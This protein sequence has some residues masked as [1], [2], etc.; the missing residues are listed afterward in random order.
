MRTVLITN[1]NLSSMIALGDWLAR[2]PARIEKIFV[3]Y[4]LPSSKGNWSGLYQMLKRSGVAYTFLKIWINRWAPQRVGQGS[5]GL[6]S[7]VLGRADRNCPVE[8]VA[9]ANASEVIEQI[10]EIAPEVLLSFSATHRF[11]DELLSTPSVA[12]VNVHY[13]ALPRYGGLSPYFWHL[14]NGEKEYGVTV[15]KMVPT[16]DA[17]PI[18]QQAVSPVGSEKTCL[19][20][21]LKMASE[22]S[23]MLQNL[24]NQPESFD[25][26]WDQD[27]TQRSYYRHPTKAQVK[28]FDQ[29]GYRMMDAQSR[30]EF[31]RKGREVLGKGL[32]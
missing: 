14:Y 18:L 22:V 30:S 20:L 10:R 5:N 21:L 3:T 24:F 6:V 12:G 26:G 1:G 31:L 11:S 7:G 8:A 29:E 27:L 28:K 25:H 13:G 23:P 4:R 16:L 15:H 9:T 19:G 32:S 2:S 17:G